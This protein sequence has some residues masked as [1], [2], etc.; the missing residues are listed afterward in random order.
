VKA[1]NKNLEQHPTHRQGRASKQRRRIKR[2]MVDLLSQ[3]TPSA[4]TRRN[5]EF[6]AD[7]PRGN[8]FW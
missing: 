6:T 5:L 1:T 4:Y 7:H 2:S 8:E 3:I